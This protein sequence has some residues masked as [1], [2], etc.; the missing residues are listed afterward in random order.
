[1][2]K[3]M[4]IYQS[5]NIQIMITSL[6]KLASYAN[7]DGGRNTTQLR[8]SAL[9]RHPTATKNGKYENMMSIIH[10][11]GEGLTVINPFFLCGK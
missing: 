3:E 4:Y 9:R 11:L 8:V 10:Y 5:P 2:I 1:M 7:R 6:K